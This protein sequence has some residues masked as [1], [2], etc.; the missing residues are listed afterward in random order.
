MEAFDSCLLDGAV[1]PFH[2]PICPGMIDLGEA[3]LNVVFSTCAGKDVFKGEPV[4]LPIG[5]LNTIIGKDGMDFIGS[6][7]NKL[8]QERGRLHFSSRCYQ[9]D[10]G[11]F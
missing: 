7:L 8:V 5:K 10:K 6:G 9:F 1:H 2:L 4:F 11:E 3:M